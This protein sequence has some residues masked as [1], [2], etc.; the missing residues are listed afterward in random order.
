MFEEG[1]SCVRF[2]RT[3]QGETAALWNELQQLCVGVR[4]TEERGR[5][6]WLLENSGNFNI[7]SMYNDL[8]NN[9]VMCP[10]KKLW[11]IKVPVKIN[12][13]MWLLF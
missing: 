2:R 3:L 8:E 5:C 4:L 9:Q 1:W 12:V 10:L 6:K 11:F 13:F 7:K